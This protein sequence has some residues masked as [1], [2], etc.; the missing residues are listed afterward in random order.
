MWIHCLS[1]FLQPT[2]IDS[3][4]DTNN[5]ETNLLHVLALSDNN[6]VSNLIISCS[7]LPFFKICLERSDFILVRIFQIFVVAFMYGL[8][9][10][11]IAETI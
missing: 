6:A 5:T 10:V 9:I 7:E 4:C 3:Y 1:T 8:E 2:Y 11:T